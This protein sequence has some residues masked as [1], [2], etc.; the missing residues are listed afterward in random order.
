M[1]MLALAITT[2]NYFQKKNTEA[3]LHIFT[4]EVQ[5]TTEGQN[6]SSS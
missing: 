4:I 6:F 1:E 2:Y 5:P 3:A